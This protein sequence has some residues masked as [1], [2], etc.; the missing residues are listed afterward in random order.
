MIAKK[1][2]LAMSLATALAMPVPGVAQ[3][4]TP[5]YPPSTSA[6][7]NSVVAAVILTAM[8]VALAVMAFNGG[9]T[10]S[11]K[12]GKTDPYT[13]RTTGPVLMDF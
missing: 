12:G 11:S 3:S 5:S 2:I 6:G 9:T 13:G 10:V 8:A 1:T 4:Y 7:D